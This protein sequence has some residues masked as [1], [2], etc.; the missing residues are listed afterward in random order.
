MDVTPRELRDIDI[1]EG[2]RGY[3]RDDVDELL[4]RAAATIEG[5]NERM[6]RLTE[7]VSSVEGQQG[8]SRETEDML[9]RTLLLAQRAA[10]EAV[11]EAQFKARQILDDAESKSRA[12]LAE[13]ESTA[14]RQVDSERRRLESEV[15]ELGS[16]RE[17]L[18][19][20]VDGL[21]RFESEYRARLRRALEADLESLAG[22]GPVAPSARPPIHDV[23]LP[24]P[25]RRASRR[26]RADTAAR[27]RSPRTADAPQPPS[28]DAGPP[29]AEIRGLGTWD[30]PSRATRRRRRRRVQHTAARVD[31]ATRRVTAR[32]RAD[33]P[34]TPLFPAEQTDAEPLDDEAFFAS[35][36]E[37]VSDQSPLGPRD[38]IPDSTGSYEDDDAKLRPVPPPPLAAQ[39]FSIRRP[40]DGRLADRDRLVIR[41]VSGALGLQEQ[42]P[43]QDLAGDPVPMRPRPLR[44]AA[45]SA[46]QPGHDAIGDLEALG[47][48]VVVERRGSPRGRVLR[49]RGRG[50][51]RVSSATATPPSS[52]SANSS[53]DVARTSTSSGSSR[54]D[55]AVDVEHRTRRRSRARA[56]SPR[57]PPSASCCLHLAA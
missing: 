19:A 31:A 38:E 30:L 48:A 20:D 8:Q 25:T 43:G 49:A 22:Q 12:Q 33:A 55:R 53:C 3:N 15:L 35:L 13:A 37:A 5:L 2:F 27:H 28:T 1:R 10:D 23:D 21:E 52:A 26:R 34:R 18:L 44:R 14:R 40:A 16:R 6:R 24:A 4:E 54:I 47:L 17:A 39:T 9:H 7:Q 56:G 45:P 46:A 42:L 50:R 41:S 51:A 32:R 36:R 11:A 57:R 29:T